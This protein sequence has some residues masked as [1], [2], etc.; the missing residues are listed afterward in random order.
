MCSENDQWHQ[1]ASIIHNNNN[2]NLFLKSSQLKG[3]QRRSFS[4]WNTCHPHLHGTP[5]VIVHRDI[6][7]ANVLLSVPK[8]DVK[9]ADFGLSTKLNGSKIHLLRGTPGDVCP[10]SEWLLVEFTRD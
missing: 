8:L 2:N 3:P 4:R 10:G 6:K 5:G 7:P 1:R 9:L